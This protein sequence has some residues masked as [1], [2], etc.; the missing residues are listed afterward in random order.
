MTVAPYT[1]TPSAHD[2]RPAPKSIP[3]PMLEPV[4]PPER[5]RLPEP[6]GDAER[7]AAEVTAAARCVGWLLLLVVLGVV[8]LVVLT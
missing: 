7:I 3:T 2:P 5:H 8:G 1:D 4:A 6:S